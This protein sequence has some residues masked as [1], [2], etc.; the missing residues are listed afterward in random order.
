[1]CASHNETTQTP[2]NENKTV[3]QVN[4]VIK[5]NT[6]FCKRHFTWVAWHI[7]AKQDIQW[8]NNYDRTR[9]DPSGIKL[10]HGKWV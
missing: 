5:V 7:W 10:D 6:A 1:M 3:T 8:E 4:S 9:F 2:W